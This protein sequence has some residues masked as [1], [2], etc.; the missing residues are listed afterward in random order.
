M[1]KVRDWAIPVGLILHSV[2]PI[3]AG[4][5]RLLQ[6]TSGAASLEN[7]RYFGAPLPFVLHM[8]SVTVFSLL[9]ALQFAPGLRRALPRWH[10]LAGRVVVPAGLMAAGTGLWMDQYYALPPMMGLRFTRSDWSS[11][12]SGCSLP[13]VGGIWRSGKRISGPIRTI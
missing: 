12:A 8:L 4:T 10:R 9:G 6:L 7:A 3:L 1:G 13:C 11:S 5:V 2:I